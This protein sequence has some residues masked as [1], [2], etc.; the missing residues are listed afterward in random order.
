MSWF[1]GTETV[2][3]TTAVDAAA[4]AATNPK[5]QKAAREFAQDKHV[6]AAATDF[7]SDKKIQAAFLKSVGVP[8][9][10]TS[11]PT[12]NG[13]S[14]EGSRKKR[15][16]SAAALAA[17]A[18]FEDSEMERNR[19]TPPTKK[20]GTTPQTPSV[21]NVGANT[22]NPSRRLDPHHKRKH[23]HKQVVPLYM[24]DPFPNQ[25]VPESFRQQFQLYSFVGVEEEETKTRAAAQTVDF[26]LVDLLERLYHEH[27]KASSKN[28][29]VQKQE[30]EGRHLQKLLL[31]YMQVQEP[32]RKTRYSNSATEEGEQAR[33]ATLM[34]QRIQLQAKE[35]QNRIGW[36]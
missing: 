36:K 35:D 25:N 12:Q 7:A 15:K 4:A 30:Q 33:L 14:N 2:T 13:A 23:K 3:T 26:P 24:L 18:A 17:M 31:A 28:P 21:N 29:M 6:Q 32:E 5:A 22:Q 8:T 27:T 20:N 1:W 11:L 10:S 9:A 16:P 34:M 19:E